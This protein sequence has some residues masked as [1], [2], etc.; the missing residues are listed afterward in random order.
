MKKRH[1]N[2]KFLLQT[3]SQYVT[4]M[5]R[6]TLRLWFYFLEKEMQEPLIFCPLYYEIMH[7]KTKRKFTLLVASNSDFVSANVI[8]N[9]H[10]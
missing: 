10:P 9:Q 8:L 5:Y 3:S 1:F 2:I 6:N 4:E 7:L